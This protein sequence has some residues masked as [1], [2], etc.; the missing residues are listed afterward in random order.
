MADKYARDVQ[1]DR[2]RAAYMDYLYDLYSRDEA[3]LG[4]RSTYT[5]LA[6]QH[7]KVLG[8]AVMDE[9]ILALGKEVM[10]EE[11]ATWHE[12]ANASSDQTA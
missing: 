3:P 4:L 8:Q 6:E 1:H 2:N 5:G 9:K 10:D 11:V 12:R 7:R